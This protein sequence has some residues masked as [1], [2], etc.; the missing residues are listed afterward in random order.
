M[1]L[2]SKDII[3]TAGFFQTVFTIV[4]ALSIGEALKQ[5]IADKAEKP[6]DR[7]I[8]W[9]RL[10]AL[11]SFLLLVLPFFHGMSRYFFIV[12]INAAEVPKYYGAYLMF[13]GA[14][15]IS[16]SALFFAM[17][18]CLPAIQW[19]RYFYLIILLL[20]VDTVWILIAVGARGFP[21]SVWLALN[22]A[23]ATVLSILLI[24]IRRQS[25][26]VA[27]NVSIICA[28]TSAITTS[29]SYFVKWD[30]FFPG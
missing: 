25:F 27:L 26:R 13:D 6:E 18:R 10:P 17:S 23:L 7:A 21:V 28:V 11:L 14:A 4:L 9:D 15:F 3:N 30:V 19:R 8:H 2:S 5:F 12:Y 29:I 24:F 22:A 1:L 20:A 16:M